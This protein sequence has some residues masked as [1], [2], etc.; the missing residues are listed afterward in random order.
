[1]GMQTFQAAP[2]KWGNSLGVIIPKDILEAEG[3]KE[4]EEI[5]ISVIK[6]KQSAIWELAGTLDDQNM[7]AKEITDAIDE[8]LYDE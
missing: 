1:M 3:V 8:E 7:S 6:R 4:G 5:E 2:K